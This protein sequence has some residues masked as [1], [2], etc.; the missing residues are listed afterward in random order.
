MTTVTKHVV[1]TIC[2][3]GCQ[4]RAVADD[5]K[6]TKILPHEHP[7]LAKN[8]CYKGTAAPQIHN[9]ADRLRTPLKRAGRRGEN[10]WEPISYAQAMDEIAER[11]QTIV[12]TRGPEA[13]A[14]STSNWNTAVENGMG[15]RF[16]NLLGTPN[17]ISGVAMCAGNT[18]AVNKLTYGW[19]PIGDFPNTDCIVLFGHNPRKHSWTPIYNAINAARERGAQVIV[20]DPRV[21][22]QAAV[23]D[24]HLPLRAGTD[25]AMCLGWLNVIITERLYDEAF[26]RDW[27]IGFD[28]LAARVAEYPL[29]RVAQICDV[30]AELIR[31]AARIYAR[32]KGA[33]I[34][35]TPTTDQQVSSTS[36]IR[37]QSIL[38]AVCGHLDV[39][40]GEM[41]GGFSPDFVP[42]SRLEYH[43]ALPAAQRAKQLGADQ[44]PVYTYRAQDLLGDA[45][46]RVYG[47]RYANIVMGSYMANPSAVFRA[48]A[49]GD[50]YAVKAFFVLGNNAL[51]SYP[52][53]QLVHRALL[54]QELIVAHE[55]FLTPTAQL[56]DYVL[57]GDVFTERN[58]VADTWNWTTRLT[59][60]EQVVP[61]PGE[62]TSTFQFWR[63][64]A[65]RMGF[66]EHFPW[67]TLDDVLD[68]RCAPMGKTFAEFA[69]DAVMR[70]GV[71]EY[72]RY[73]K[74]GFATPSGKV[75]LRSSILERL[76][77]DPLPYFREPP[78][79][80]AEYPFSVFI[81]V[82]EDPYFQ[83]GQRN[84]EVL[85]RRSPAPKTFVHPDDAAEHGLDDG[86]WARIESA[87]GGIVAKVSVQPSMKR[88][89]LR[90]PH[91]W[92]FPEVEPDESL[93][94]AFLCND[95]MLAADDDAHLDLEQ[96]VPHFK[97]FP[98]RI[99]KLDSPP[100]LP[101][102]VLQG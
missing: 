88:G 2:D 44:H 32:A 3:I 95:G 51:M 75:E 65:V 68:Y 34:P 20:L 45:T 74:H 36:A 57:P 83:T 99:T 77:F 1:C 53:Q 26:V 11:L 87:H 21:S 101:E 50:P 9:H 5:G 73:R 93:S 66:E 22:D 8:I 58:N 61:A 96:G 10:R 49:D 6:V 47:Y 12:D 92:W 55:L 84:I 46:E 76:G 60:S 39:V 97:G 80:S 79:V 102:A 54:N 23:A 91:G 63:D 72:R 78:A 81:G 100:R 71:P 37:L 64:L 67:K 98:G 85:R 89:H 41:L 94:G 52:N 31:K 28:E 48:M 14:V 7:L 86:D 35:W 42:E 29:E 24:L 4:L 27:T 25:A 43:E 19:F 13:L 62:C 17:W 90:V 16:M 30:D 38:R 56:A 40:G 70:A 33:V 82:R 69:S 59:V 18:A 15:R